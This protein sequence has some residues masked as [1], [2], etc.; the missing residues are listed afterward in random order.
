LKNF[1]VFPLVLCLIIGILVGTLLP[2]PWQRET[3]PLPPSAVTSDGSTSASG[4][5]RTSS[6]PALDTKDNV[7][8]LNAAGTVVRALKEAD[9][10]SVAALVHP[11]KG[12]TFTP[13][14]S[15]NFDTDLTFTA[16]QIR[17][18]ASDSNS[19]VWGF[20]DGRGSLIELTPA[21]Y[22]SQYVFNADYTQATLI[23]IDRVITSGNALENVAEAYPGC[24]FVDF[25]FPSIEPANQGMDWCSLKLVFEPGETSW[26]LVGIIHGQW[27]T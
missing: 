14:S 10:A 8:L 19:Y 21:Q 25:C 6:Q 18:L 22:F 17:G 3:T 24:R 1:H 20:V 2:T 26:Q 15:V 27:T 12:V 23:G 13:Y 16:D 4:A 11:T 5:T 7:A 9:Y